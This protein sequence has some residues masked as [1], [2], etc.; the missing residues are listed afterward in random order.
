MN[1][2]DLTEEQ[3]QQLVAKLPET[4][5]LYW[6]QRDELSTEDL[7][8]LCDA[9]EGAYEVESNLRDL[10]LEAEWQLQKEAIDEALRD[11][12]LD[13]IDASDVWQRL[14]EEEKLGPKLGFDV[15]L[16]DLAR[17]TR[18]V[19]LTVVC[20]QELNFEAWQGV[21]STAQVKELC[22]Y[23]ELLNINP[24]YLQAYVVADND[25][26]PSYDPEPVIFPDFP[27]REGHEKMLPKD[28]AEML[29]NMCY[30][31]TLVFLFRLDGLELMDTIAG[32]KQGPLRIHRG[33]V[34]VF[35]DFYNGAGSTE[36]LLTQDLVLEPGSYEISFDAGR[37]YGLQSCY[38]F[39]TQVWKAG[40]VT[41]ED[42]PESDEG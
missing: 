21:C 10:N 34:C 32:L 7:A 41:V 23:C 27:E 24:R 30:A 37:R 1:I 17:N 6:D 39:T 11:M 18:G 16:K 4:V 12:D 2:A 40:H 36:G 25:K 14:Q 38:G 33:T 28:F 15:N 8:K 26:R 3:W 22:A 9:E 35:Y 5:K 29:D 31:G 19:N 42:T 20:K 13:E